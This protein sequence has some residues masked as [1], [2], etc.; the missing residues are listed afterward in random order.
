MNYPSWTTWLTTGWAPLPELRCRPTAK[1]SCRYQSSQ[2]IQQSS[3]PQ[4]LVRLVHVLS[5]EALLW[6]VGFFHWFRNCSVGFSLQSW[7]WFIWHTE[8]RSEWFTAHALFGC[9][10]L[11]GK[12]GFP[13][14]APAISCSVFCL[15]ESSWMETISLQPALA[16][17]TFICNLLCVTLPF[18]SLSEC[19]ALPVDV[20]FRIYSV[21]WV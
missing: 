5:W 19:C 7:A 14:G 9:I 8:W 3:F 4:T 11:W 16:R 15:S 13:V 12:G 20:I 18:P 10:P 21:C 2:C 17:N 6:H 1:S